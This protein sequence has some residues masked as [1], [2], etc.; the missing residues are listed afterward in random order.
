MTDLCTFFLK[1]VPLV[2][3]LSMYYSFKL[4]KTGAGEKKMLKQPIELK[5]IASALQGDQS[6]LNTLLEGCQQ[7]LKQHIRQYFEYHCGSYCSEIDD[8]LQETLIAI[9]QHIKDCHEAEKFKAWILGIAH[10]KIQDYLRHYNDA[11]IYTDL[12]IDTIN[13][14]NHL[15]EFNDINSPESL[16]IQ[17]ERHEL[18]MQAIDELSPAYKQV[19]QLTDIEECSYAEAAEKLHCSIGTLKSR[20][21][22]AR[23]RVKN[24]IINKTK[25]PVESSTKKKKSK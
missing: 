18:Y 22:R 6:A 17:A 20:L 16:T 4:R 10:H 14:A 1:L 12:D 11:I 3:N 9:A 23:E 21:S 25:K 15:T 8:I 19:M 2:Y 5:L 7:F 24:N 13:E